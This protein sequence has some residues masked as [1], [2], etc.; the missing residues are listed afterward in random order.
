[1][2]MRLAWR[3]RGVCGIRTGLVAAGLLLAV[4]AQ[5]QTAR[6]TIG[7]V[8]AENFYGDVASQIGGAQVRVTSILS[9]RDE[10][11]HLF[12]AS[13]S[14]ARAISAARIVVYSGIDYD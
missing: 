4:S 8:A 10:D 3:L 2:S 14:V 11:P 9:N 5:A 13:P 1:M 12:E 6:G 7:V